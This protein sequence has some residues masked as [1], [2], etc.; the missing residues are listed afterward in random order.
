M[1]KK[2]LGMILIVFKQILIIKIQMWKL[3]PNFYAMLRKKSQKFYLVRLLVGQ[4]HVP[5]TL[6]KVLV[7]GQVLM[8]FGF[9]PGKETIMGE[10]TRLAR[11]DHSVRICGLHAE[12]LNHRNS[13]SN[14]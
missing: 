9:A 14:T 1:G 7:Q 11:P 3:F 5:C 10:K 2:Y 12:K 13:D 6:Y 4:G 8:C